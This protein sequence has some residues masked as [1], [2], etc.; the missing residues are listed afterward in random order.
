MRAG[1]ALDARRAAWSRSGRISR[2]RRPGSPGMPATAG[3]APAAGAAAAPPPRKALTSSLVTR[4]FSP[5]PLT[6][7]RSRSSSR[8]RRRTAGAGVHAAKIG[9]CRRGEAGAP[10]WRRGRRGRRRRSGGGSSCDR[11]GRRARRRRPGAQRRRLRLQ[12]SGSAN[13]RSTLS[14][15]LTEIFSTTPPAARALPSSPCRIP[16]MISGSSALTVSPGFTSISMTGT[17]L[18]S[19]ISGTLTSMRP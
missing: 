9:E 17:F 12:A 3:D 14:P 6:L 1:D 18:K 8:A 11:R 13:P 19:P 10:R 5:V 15:T 4:P 7:V 2:S 16:A